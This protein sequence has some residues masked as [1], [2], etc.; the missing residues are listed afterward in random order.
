MMD[1]S[2][3]ANGLSSAGVDCYSCLQRGELPSRSNRLGSPW[4]PQVASGRS[5]FREEH[6]PVMLALINGTPGA[7][8]RVDAE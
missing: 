3:A 7:F 8:R 1:R 2:H 5:L 4:F 6:S